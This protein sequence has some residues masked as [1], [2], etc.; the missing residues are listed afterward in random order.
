MSKSYN[1]I[2]QAITAEPWAIT[3]EKLALVETIV[4]RAVENP[5]AAVNEEFVKRGKMEIRVMNGIPI[6]PVIGVINRRMNLFSEISGGTS[7]EKMD[8][9]FKEALAMPG[10]AVIFHMD[11]PGGSVSGVPEFGDMI[12]KASRDSG[13]TIIACGDGMMAS[14]AY[15]LAAKCDEIYATKASVIGSIGVI[16]S[17]FDP[18]R[19]YQNEGYDPVTIR[20]SELKGSGNGHITPNQMASMQKRVDE[21]YAMFKAEVRSGRPG[22]DIEAVSTGET[23]LGEEAKRL[24]LIDGVATLDEVV[25]KYS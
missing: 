3:P 21:Y 13:K 25:E 9:M 15:W 22:I 8:K 7:I 20:S 24:K 18:T 2:A 10:K 12:A 11:S 17:F 5:N 4:E 16:A 23:W 1:R 19:A 14:A 6:V